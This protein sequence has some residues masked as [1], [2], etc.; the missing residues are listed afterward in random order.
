MVDIKVYGADWCPLTKMALAHL[1]RRGIK[2]QYIDIDEDKEAARWVADQNDGKEK[3]PT[4]DI[5]GRV[6]STPSNQELD[7]A[8]EAASQ[9]AP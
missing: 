5:G 1:D 9:P 3:K 7:E 2:Y 4:I 8:L 6:L